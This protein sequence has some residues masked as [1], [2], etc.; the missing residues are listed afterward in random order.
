MVP[1]NINVKYFISLYIN[2]CSLWFYWNRCVKYYPVEIKNNVFN[3]QSVKVEDISL[4]VEL[5][6]SKLLGTVF[7]KLHFS[8]VTTF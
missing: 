7:R 4:S 8:C 3:D 2:I 1:G 6:A 5:K